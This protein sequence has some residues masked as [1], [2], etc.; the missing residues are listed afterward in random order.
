MLSD[1]IHRLRSLF[2]RNRVEQELDDELQFHLE[3]ET[4]KLV[5]RGLSHA[6][7]T[8]RARLSLGGAEQ[9]KEHV[10]EARGTRWLEDLAQDLRYAVRTSAKSPAFT[11]TVVATLALGI[12]ATTAL[13][14]VAHAVLLRWLPVAHPQEL[15]VLARDPNQPYVPHGRADY[16]RLRDYA[17][18]SFQGVAAAHE[19]GTAGFSMEQA[20]HSGAPII[21]NLAYVSGTYFGVLGVQPTAGRM[22][23]KED[24]AA[25]GANRYVVLDHG[26]WQR[27]LG[28]DLTVLGRTVRL[29][30]VLCTVVGIASPGFHGTQVGNTPD[31]YVPLTLYPSLVPTMRNNWDRRW[32]QWLTITARLRPGVTMA[33]AE[34]QVTSL[35]GD[36]AAE[37]SRLGVTW[38]PGDGADRSWRPTLLP[39]AQGQSPLRTLY[40]KPLVVLLAAAGL[41]LVLS[42]A[43]VAGLILTRAGSRQREIAMRLAV[44]ASRGRVVRQLLTENLLLAALGGMV[45]VALGVGGS[46]ALVNLLS[47]QMADV[48]LDVSPDPSVLAVSF[49]ATV[50][51][52]LLFGLAPALRSS[53]QDL[54]EALKRSPSV[55]GRV[56]RRLSARE[57]LVVAQVSLCL[58]LLVGVALLARSFAHLQTIDPGFARDGVLL[59][60]VQPSQYGY[61]GARAR[62]FYERLRERVA[63]L[64]GVR[65]VGLS[66]ETPLGGGNSGGTASAPGRFGVGAV[67]AYGVSAGYLAAMG[68]PLVSGRYFSVD[69]E[70]PGAPRVGLVTESLARRL[71]PGENPIGRRLSREEQYDARQSFEIVGVVGDARYFGLRTPPV[72]TVYV[73]LEPAVRSLALSV[74]TEGPPES[75]IPAVR[76]ETAALDPAVPVL[77]AHTIRHRL[78]REV[79]QERLLSILVSGFGTLALVLVAVGLYGVLAQLVTS[80]TKEFGIRVALGARRSN[81]IGPVLG[82][83]VR[84]VGGGAAIGLLGALASV[85]LLARFLY[86]VPPFDVPSFLMAFG[87]L[88]VVALVASGVPARRAAQVN[89]VVALRND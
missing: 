30:S 39:G 74:R 14:S 45:G 86:G 57:I 40:G 59:V 85:R 11:L 77:M 13:F 10:R 2:C 24:E 63:A 7:A 31:V 71:F 75:L 19:S 6:E 33:Q 61:Q 79:A 68:I 56:Q 32:R 42:C 26:F 89:P 48:T 27:Q 35:L 3:C 23:V 28:G 64:P 29:N 82:D 60:Q 38:G 17:G 51:A 81:I 12:G 72:P 80:R 54:T 87:V 15:V 58:V 62:A 20:G 46:K 84:L 76:R 37:S 4:E 78:D 8:R 53:R 16:L 22:L 47:M 55:F 69:D 36:R 66:E 25:P 1:P 52:G 88:S 41:L 9:V 5:Q 21:V 18:Q 34:A 43:N 73:P 50:L 83:M 67:E 70:V 65:A 44:G 49:V